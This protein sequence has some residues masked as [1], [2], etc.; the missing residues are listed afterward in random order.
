MTRGRG[1][2]NLLFT[3]LWWRL[4]QSALLRCSDG[5]S[6]QVSIV[7]LALPCEQRDCVNSSKDLSAIA[8]NNTKES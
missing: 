6:L 2:A 4:T 8:E 5:Y 3:Q 7:C 1:I